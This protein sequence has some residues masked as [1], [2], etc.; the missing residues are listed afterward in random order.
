M[1][2]SDEPAGSTK[3]EVEQKHFILFPGGQLRQPHRV[4]SNLDSGKN[5]EVAPNV[6]QFDVGVG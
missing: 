4:N 5:P 3:G 2:Y 6:V 1:A